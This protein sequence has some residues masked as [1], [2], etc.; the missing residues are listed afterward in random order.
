MSRRA[1]IS[2]SNIAPVYY[3]FSSQTTFY[4]FNF[5]DPLAIELD[6]GTTEP[7]FDLTPGVLA[8]RVSK[9][10]LPALVRKE[11]TDFSNGIGY[12]SITLSIDGEQ[13]FKELES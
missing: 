5:A 1:P 3:A 6:E 11:S 9:N 7:L 8:I 10:E 2:T 4:K 13:A 12:G